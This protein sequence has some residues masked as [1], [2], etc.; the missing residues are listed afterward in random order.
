MSAPRRV[1]VIDF[2]GT[3]LFDSLVAPYIGVTDFQTHITRLQAGD[4]DDG[5]LVFMVGSI[6]VYY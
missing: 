4:L 1:S 5:T 3:M 6:L 2:E